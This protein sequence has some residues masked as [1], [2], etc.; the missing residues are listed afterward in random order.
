MTTEHIPRV[1]TDSD[2]QRVEGVIVSTQPSSTKLMK[3]KLDGRETI[4]R[5][6]DRV[7]PLNEA[8]RKFLGK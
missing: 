6:V 8:A 3:I 5:H 7:T 4:V 1:S 2:G